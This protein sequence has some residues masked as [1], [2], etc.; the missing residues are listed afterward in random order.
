VKINRIDLVPTEE[1]ADKG[2]TERNE[3]KGQGKLFSSTG[4]GKVDVSYHSG[5]NPELSSFVKK[6]AKPYDLDTDD[7]HR[8]SFNPQIR[9]S[10]A[11]P[12]YNMHT[13]WS[14]KHYKAIMQYIEHFTEPGDLVLDQFCGSGMTGVAA[15]ATGRVPILID[16]SPA[17]TFITRSY[18]D[19]VDPGQLHMEFD[20]VMERVKPE[21]DWLYE[22]RCDRCGGRATT[23]YVVWSERFQC[24]RC[25]RVVPLYDCPKVEVP[26][27]SG[28]GYK[29][30]RVCPHCLDEGIKNEINTQNQKRGRIP[31]EVCY[32]CLDGCS[33]K[34]SSRSHLDAEQRKRRYFE[35]YD[36]R[37]VEEIA[38][39]DIPYWYP[40]NRM[41]NAAGE[42]GRWGYLWRRGIHN[43][44]D[45]IHDLFTKRNLWALAA[46]LAH[47]DDS[48]R[49]LLT[50]VLFNTS[51]LYR[52]RPSLKG[53][54][55]MGTYYVPAISQ[56]MNVANSLID[57]LSKIKKGV[58]KAQE[59]L[60]G[61]C[62][63]STQS[64]TRLGTQ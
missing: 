35:E 23:G 17:A 15:L 33:P 2:M 57:K 45:Y 62:C 46:F 61:Y 19:P 60:S 36:L 10:K 42:Q 52:W 9:V 44:I 24:D 37:K 41:C 31:V 3:P 21:L 8:D 25:L 32:L 53:G 47:A 50:A 63:I 11:D 54:I 40:T 5:P 13:Y 58:R 64:A 26:K 22:T 20:R 1:G 18:C 30:V 7:Y 55:Q 14:K 34:R 29:T 49:F 43:D 16:L 51:L 59:L 27:K 39:Q 38:K 4:F 6:H 48:L 56:V 28:D 12:I